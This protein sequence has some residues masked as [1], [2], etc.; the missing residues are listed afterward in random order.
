MRTTEQD[1]A[2]YVRAVDYECDEDPIPSEAYIEGAKNEYRLLTEW[3]TIPSDKIGLADDKF[4]KLL[5]ASLPILVK[6]IA[7]GKLS[8][9]DKYDILDWSGD[10]YHHPHQYLW[11]KIEG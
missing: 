11:R 10:L 7:T 3:H 2:Q 1:A 5:C 4:Y 8:V 6:E 9:V